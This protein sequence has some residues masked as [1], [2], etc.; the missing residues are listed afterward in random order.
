MDPPPVESIRLADFRNQNLASSGQG[1][2]GILGAFTIL[3]FQGHLKYIFSKRILNFSNFTMSFQFRRF[4]RFFRTGDNRDIGRKAETAE[5]RERGPFAIS[6]APAGR[7]GNGFHF[8]SRLESS[9]CNFRIALQPK[10][11]WK[12]EIDYF[13]FRN[14]P[15]WPYI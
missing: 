12:P 11:A 3:I 9:R 6:G 15:Q 14:E 5:S 7:S 13:F 4:F 10:M 8:F 1:K 2:V